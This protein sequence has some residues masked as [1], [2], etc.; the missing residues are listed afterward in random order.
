MDYEVFLD[1]QETQ[2]LIS[3]LEFNNSTIVGLDSD[4]I[5]VAGFGIGPG[6]N[7]FILRT[8]RDKFNNYKKEK[9]R[10]FVVKKEKDLN[11]KYNL[12]H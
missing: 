10:V 2:S 9:L 8:T 11:K 7:G 3:E 12:I 1:T 6:Q 4:G 5:S